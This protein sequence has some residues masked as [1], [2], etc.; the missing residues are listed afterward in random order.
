MITHGCDF[1]EPLLSE[2]L[3]SE[4]LFSESMNNSQIDF[5]TLTPQMTFGQILWIIM[6]QRKHNKRFDKP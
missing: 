2:P 3:L 6:E 5:S 4:S 1:N